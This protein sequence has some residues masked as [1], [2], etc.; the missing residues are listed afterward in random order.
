MEFYSAIEKNKIMKLARRWVDLE[1][2]QLSELTQI[3]QEKYL[4]CVSYV[5]LGF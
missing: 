5:V 1:I 3:Q 4:M 2:T